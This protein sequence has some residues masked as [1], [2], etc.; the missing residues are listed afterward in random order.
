MRWFV[1][2]VTLIAIALLLGCNGN[3]KLTPGIF[4]KVISKGTRQPIANA[5]VKVLSGDVE[6]ASVTT[7]G[8]GA[9]AFPN[10]LPGSYTLVVSAEGYW[11]SRV[12]VTLETNQRLSV[13]VEL[14]SEQE[15]PPT[16]VP[17]TD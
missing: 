1:L 2:L 15:G 10:L 14:Y 17:I 6:V 8:N 3:G 11:E 12:G 13:T 16:D 4:G 7:N 9:F 5:T